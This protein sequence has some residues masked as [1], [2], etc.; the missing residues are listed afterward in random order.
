MSVFLISLRL[1]NSTSVQVAD[2][3][4]NMSDIN[5]GQEMVRAV[6][7]ELPGLFSLPCWL[8]GALEYKGLLKTEKTTLG[9]AEIGEMKSKSTPV[10]MMR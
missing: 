6:C 4:T 7:I 2:I 9:Q 5:N 3:S 10:D 8:S 1:P